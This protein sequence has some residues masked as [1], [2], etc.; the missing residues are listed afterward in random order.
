[1]CIVECKKWN[2]RKKQCFWCQC[3]VWFKQFSWCRMIMIEHN[4][5]QRLA[6]HVTS[7]FSVANLWQWPRRS[8]CLC[9]IVWQLTVK[10]GEL[11]EGDRSFR[12]RRFVCE[13]GWG[14]NVPSKTVLTKVAMSTLQ[15]GNRTNLW[16]WTDRTCG[17]Q[18]S[19]ALVLGNNMAFCYMLHAFAS[20]F[21]EWGYQ[22]PCLLFCDANIWCFIL[23]PQRKLR[24]LKWRNER[25]IDPW[26]TMAPKTAAKAEAKPKAKADAKAKGKAKA[27]QNTHV[28]KILHDPWST[29]GW[30]Y[31]IVSTFWNKKTKHALIS[32]KTTVKNVLAP[33]GI[34]TTG[35]FNSVLLSNSLS[36]HGSFWWFWRYRRRRRRCQRR[37]RRTRCHSLTVLSM[38]R[39]SLAQFWH[40]KN[41][42]NFS[43]MA[44]VLHFS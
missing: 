20:W 27:W 28:T 40:R 8:K 36:L 10:I 21:L 23:A 2:L 13:L 22:I 6:A 32:A 33:T 5:Q 38:M 16:K 41:N 15:N 30:I 1:M 18:I 14:L 11:F 19:A 34:D 4:L 43:E 3:V 39:R 24:S 12:A 26:L 35:R 9:K 37:R 44:F 25:R 31:N 29:K 7:P 42:R 17:F